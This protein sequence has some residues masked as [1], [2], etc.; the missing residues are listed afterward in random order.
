[1]KPFPDF[2]FFGADSYRVALTNIP[3]RN[4][5]PMAIYQAKKHPL[6]IALSTP[7]HQL[8]RFVY[9]GMPE[10]LNENMPL[11]FPPALFGALNVCLAYLLFRKIGFHEKQALL[12]TTFY[13]AAA[14]VWIFAGF[15]ETYSCTSLFTN[16][17]YPC[18]PR[19]YEVEEIERPSLQPCAGLLRRTPTGS[20]GGHPSVPV[21]SR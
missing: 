1:M 4:W 3:A 11:S 16:L 9:G 19:R 10:P 6:F 20:S 7:L 18:F 13:G 17:Y 8:G 14:A 2:W 5:H 12:P 21:P 15:P